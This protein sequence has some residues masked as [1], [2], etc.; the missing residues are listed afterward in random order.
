M[1]PAI[2]KKLRSKI[3]GAKQSNA[4]QILKNLLNVIEVGE[5][6]TLKNYVGM[7]LVGSLEYL[8][9]SILLYTKIKM[10]CVLFAAI[11]KRQPE[12]V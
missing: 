12:M 4:L 8:K 1:L 6:K 10:A 3:G 9:L 2:Q 11:Q 5:K 7:K